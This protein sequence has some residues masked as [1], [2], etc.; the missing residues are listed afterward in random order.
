ML[1]TFINRR[2]T[3]LID[4]LGAEPSYNSKLVWESLVRGPAG[5]T[6]LLIHERGARRLYR[7]IAANS[8]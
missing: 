5:K 8:T 7:F 1:A 3:V 2:A 6:V 4:I